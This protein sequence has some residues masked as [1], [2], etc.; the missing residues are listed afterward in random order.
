MRPGVSVRRADRPRFGVPL[1]ARTDRR[2]APSLSACKPAP[3]RGG[4]GSGGVG[5]GR[6]VRN[7]AFPWGP[8]S[9]CAARSRSHRGSQSGVD[10]PGAK[11]EARRS[12]ASG[13]PETWEHHADRTGVQRVSGRVRQEGLE[14]EGGLRG[15]RESASQREAFADLHAPLELRVVWVRESGAQENGLRRKCSA[16]GGRSRRPDR[17]WERWAGRRAVGRAG[18]PGSAWGRRGCWESVDCP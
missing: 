14:R 10:R 5:A 3:A 7:R 11:V 8:R 9:P 13:S 12:P 16:T 17:A 2:L 18:D 1:P 6:P 15:I 4:Q